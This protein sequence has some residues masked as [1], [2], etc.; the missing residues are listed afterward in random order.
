MKQSLQHPLDNLYPNNSLF[1]LEAMIPY[2][3]PS[4]QLPIA[5]LIKLQELRTLVQFFH[6]PSRMES[7]GFNRSSCGNEE[8]MSA[9]CQTMGINLPEQMANMQNMQ[10]MMNLAGSM[11]LSPQMAPSPPAGSDIIPGSFRTDAFQPDSFQPDSFQTDS[12]RTEPADSMSHN[13]EDMIDAIRQILS[14]QEGDTYESE[15]IT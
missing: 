11:N 15:S 10:N 4:F 1:L 8:L 13:R 2:L 7:F 14:E 6:N 3:D 5:L 9:L 12:F